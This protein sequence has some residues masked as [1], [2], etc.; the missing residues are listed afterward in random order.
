MTFLN[1]INPLDFFQQKAIQNNDR[2]PEACLLHYPVLN[3]TE[4]ASLS[5]V[6]FANDP[7]LTPEAMKFCL[8][9]YLPEVKE[10]QL[11]VSFSLLF[12]LS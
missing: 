8:E 6:L 11:M 10:E 2:L 4:S 1:D 12:S 3:L 9:A 7:V 5:R